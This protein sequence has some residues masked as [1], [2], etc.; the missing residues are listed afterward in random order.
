MSVKKSSTVVIK[1]EPIDDVGSFVGGMEI[2]RTK[3]KSSI[4]FDFNPR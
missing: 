1:K 4:K 2:D 3:G